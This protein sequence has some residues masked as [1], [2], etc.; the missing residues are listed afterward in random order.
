MRLLR[1]QLENAPKCMLSEVMLSNTFKFDEAEIG[2]QLRVI[3]RVF[4]W[5]FDAYLDAEFLLAA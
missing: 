4:S 5:C 1:I 3:A 2:T